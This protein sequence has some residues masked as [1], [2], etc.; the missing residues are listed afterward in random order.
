MDVLNTTH[1]IKLSLTSVDDAVLA[2][3]VKVR[4]SYPFSTDQTPVTL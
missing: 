1:Y 3:G 2:E 4:V